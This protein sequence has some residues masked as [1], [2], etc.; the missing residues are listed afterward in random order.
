MLI[1]L[2]LQTERYI[3]GKIV[4][5]IINKLTTLN[6]LKFETTWMKQILLLNQDFWILVHMTPEKKKSDKKKDVFSFYATDGSFP[7]M[8]TVKI[9]KTKKPK[10]KKSDVKLELINT[11]MDMRQ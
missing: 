9:K 8:D 1:M 11:W 10:K 7:E 5:S 6:H 3:F 2:I 4:Y